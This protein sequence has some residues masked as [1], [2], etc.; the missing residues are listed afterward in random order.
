MEDAQKQ[1]LSTNQV[2]SF[3]LEK[4]LQVNQLLCLEI[5][6]LK[7]LL[8]EE[9]TNKGSSTPSVVSTQAIG[10]ANASISDDL[11]TFLANATS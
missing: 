8:G 7:G 11:E 4:A 10:N 5:N 9:R 6:R 1:W 3:E 2:L